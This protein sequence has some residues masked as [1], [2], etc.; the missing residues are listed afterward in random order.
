MRSV[1]DPSL[2][3]GHA[4]MLTALVGQYRTLVLHHWAT[5]EEITASDRFQSFNNQFNHHLLANI[6]DA[7]RKMES[8]RYFAPRVPRG[9]K[10]LKELLFQ[11]FWLE[12]DATFA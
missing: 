1:R 2:G 4:L 11:Q 10:P 8:L 9:R 5:S 6:V 12:S 7:Y 3:E